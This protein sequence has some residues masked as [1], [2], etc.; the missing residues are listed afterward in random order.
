[1]DFSII[2]P[3]YNSTHSLEQLNEEIRQYFM[4][5]HASYE[6]IYVD[7]HSAPPTANTLRQL[8][9]YEGVRV[10]F[11]EKNLGQQRTLLNGL[12]EAL[13]DIVVT[14]DDDLQHDICALDQIL[15]RIKAGADLVFGVYE[16]YGDQP[17]RQWGSKL[18]GFFFKTRYKSLNGNRVSS[19]RVMTGQLC[20]KLVQPK[21]RFVYISAELLR[22]SKCVE[23]IS[24]AR[25]QRR[26]GKSGY[27][28]LKCVAIT[29]KLFWYYGICSRFKI[30]PVEDVQR[31]KSADGRCRKLSN[32]CD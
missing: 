31:E 4:A 25:R 8:S 23:N 12:K 14:I 28:L 10:F 11:N 26:Y 27:N 17:A 16:N 13:G 30:Q 20:R 3:V 18:I 32:K 21:H 2:I 9:T 15:P 22:H 7:D 19:Y 24:I 6:I 1:M 5:L 29:L